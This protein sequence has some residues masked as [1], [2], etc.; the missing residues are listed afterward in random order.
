MRAAS[1]A[2]AGLARISFASATVVSA[3]STGLRRSPLR[4]TTRS[5]A[6]STFRRV[7]RRT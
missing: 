2:S 7:T 1:A 5:H 6:A 4:I 3:A